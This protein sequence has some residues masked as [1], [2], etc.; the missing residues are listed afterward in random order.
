MRAKEGRYLDCKFSA[1]LFWPRLRLKETFLKIPEEGR[2]IS[3]LQLFVFCE[4]AHFYQPPPWLK[5]KTLALGVITSDSV[6]TSTS[7][8][9]GFHVDVDVDVAL[10]SHTHIIGSRQMTSKSTSTPLLYVCGWIRDVHS[11]PL[12]KCNIPALLVCKFFLTRHNF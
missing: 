6:S 12:S 1:R 4:F 2:A 7:T 8:P 10:N 11:A 5:R 9:L 3:R